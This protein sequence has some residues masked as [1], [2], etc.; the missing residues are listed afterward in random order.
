MISRKARVHGAT[1]GLIFA[2]AVLLAACGGNSETT[3]SSSISRSSGVPAPWKVGAIVDATTVRIVS[4]VGYCAGDRRPRF[5]YV[6]VEKRGHRV[7]ISPRVL[8]APPRKGSCRGVGYFEKR[9]IDLGESLSRLQL[10]DGTTSPP[11]LRWPRR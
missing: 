11:T 7:Y 5:G 8:N 9:T 4:H 6:R 10:F 1:I 2:V 3:A